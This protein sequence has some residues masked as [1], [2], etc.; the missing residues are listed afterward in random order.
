MDS[1]SQRPSLILI[2]NTFYMNNKVRILNRLINLNPNSLSPSHMVIM[3]DAISALNFK[4]GN[5]KEC[6]K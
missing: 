2:V 3:F 5:M 6:R 4:P 1:Q